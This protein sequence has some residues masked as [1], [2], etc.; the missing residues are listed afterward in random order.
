MNYNMVSSY[1]N[2]PIYCVGDFNL[3]DISRNTNS[4]SGHQ[5]PLEINNMTLEL[6]FDCGLT[7]MVELP[8]RSRGSNILDLILTNR[9]TLIHKSIPVPE[10]SDHDIILTTFQIKATYPK[11]STRKIFLWNSLDHADIKNKLVEFSNYYTSV[12]F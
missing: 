12:F 4:V 2:V 6:L 7:Q 8:T 10:I 1:P 9:P 5:Y 3:P 11:N